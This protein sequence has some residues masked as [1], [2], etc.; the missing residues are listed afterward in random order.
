M[1]DK[2]KI[3]EE[4]IVVKRKL[5]FIAVIILL[6]AQNVFADGT[7][8]K[9]IDAG[10]W[11]VDIGGD[12]RFR[13]EQIDDDDFRSSEDGYAVM[14]N[15]VKLNLKFAYKNILNVFVET[16][17]A[18]EWTHDIKKGGQFDDM[19]LHQA[20]IY[21]NEIFPHTGLK[22]GRQ[23]LDYGKG[24][25]VSTPTWSNK[26]KAFDSVVTKLNFSDLTSDIFI[27]NEASYDDNNFNDNQGHDIFSGVYNTYKISSD[28]L[29][30]F[31]FLSEIDKNVAVRGEDNRFGHKERYT[32]G[33]RYNIIPIKDLTFDIETM[34][35][36]GRNGTSDIDAYAVSFYVEKKFTA[37]FNPS[38]KLEFNLA[39]GDGDLTDNEYNTFIP[40]H[41][42]THGSYGIIDYFRLQNIR[43]IAGF[44]SFDIT[45][46]LSLKP[47]LHWYWLDS[48][49]D[50]WYKSNGS[51][52]FSNTIGNTDSYVGAE[53]SLVA[54]YS[55]NKYIKF[56]TGYSHFFSGDVAEHARDNNGVNFGYLQ[57]ILSF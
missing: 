53:S 11:T 14:Y 23:R 31:Y 40:V 33:A 45:E 25:I 55:L 29:A 35:Q 21:F 15:R 18:R 52:I 47:E 3:S 54:V 1:A 5:L 8:L 37:K 22:I 57:T 28:S 16:L 34:Y 43:E 10:N 9:N 17:D 36:F 41:Q 56:E 46:K 39:S 51:R 38:V 12:N 24:R 13:F 7:W 6:A 48:D 2:F 42:A 20:Y 19:D 30:D 32:A 49:A 27:G 44:A 26:I 50:A 4:V